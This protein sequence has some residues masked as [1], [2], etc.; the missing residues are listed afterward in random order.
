MRSRLPL[1][2]VGPEDWGLRQK[3]SQVYVGGGLAGTGTPPALQ[4]TATQPKSLCPL[5]KSTA[6]CQTAKRSPSAE[7]R[8]AR[9]TRPATPRAAPAT[10]PAASYSPAT[11]SSP[12]G[13]TQSPADLQQS[14]ASI[15]E[16]LYALPDETPVLPGHGADTID[17]SREAPGCH[18]LIAIE[19][20]PSP[21]PSSQNAVRSS[22]WG[23]RTEG[24]RIAFGS[25]AMSRDCSRGA[26]Q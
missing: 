6:R 9:C 13:R 4:F 23:R 25:D 19:L 16:R 20:R 5:P 21:P 22:P 11:Y 1:K 3:T 18:E 15:T 14:I 24:E 8:S 10:W 26:L 2:K 17:E 12:A 7:A